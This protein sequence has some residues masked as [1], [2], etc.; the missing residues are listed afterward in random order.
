[1]SIRVTVLLTAL[2][3]LPTGSALAQ[4]VPQAV[5]APDEGWRITIY[6]VLAWIPSGIDIDLSLPPTDADGGLLGDIIDSRFDGAFLGGFSAAKGAWRMDVN[7]LWAAVGGDR[8][9]TPVFTVDAD[10]IYLH[11][12]G[13]VRMVKDLYAIGGVRRLAVK[14]NIVS[15]ALAPFERKPGVWDP[16]VGLGWHTERRHFE[17]HSEFEVGGFGAG[18][19]LEVAASLRADWKPIPH[20]GITGGYQFLYFKISDTVLG[21]EF[22]VKQTLHGPM[23]GVGLYF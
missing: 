2:C 12:T 16:L 1:V 10:V 22:T 21:R 5:P 13:G 8:L 7:G 9:E 23:V 20:F 11:A 18:A 6:P 15:E 17:V 4:S 3:L 14:Y 19:D